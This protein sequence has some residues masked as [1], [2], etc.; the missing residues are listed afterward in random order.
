MRG[1]V[2]IYYRTGFNR[3][4]AQS[5][6]YRGISEPMYVGAHTCGRHDGSEETEQE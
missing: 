2:C 6:E 4:A 1:Q 3:D 5:G